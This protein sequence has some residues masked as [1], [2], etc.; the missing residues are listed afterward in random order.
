MET[1]LKCKL[2]LVY[3]SGNFNEM[4]ACKMT[5]FSLLYTYIP[6]LYMHR[7]RTPYTQRITLALAL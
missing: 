2:T 3:I 4:N 5:K 1:Y 7:Y 6:S